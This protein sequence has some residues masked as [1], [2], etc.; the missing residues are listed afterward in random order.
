MT[1]APRFLLGIDYGT[2][3]IGLAWGDRE[4]CLAFALGAHQEGRDGS[5]MDHIAAI[6][7]ERQIQRIVI[8]LPRR[9]DGSEGEIADRARRFAGLLEERLGL[10]CILWDERYSSQEADRWLA[11]RARRGQKGDRDSLAA[12]I[13][14]QSYLD[15]L[16]AGQPEADP[17]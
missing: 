1:D 7:Q 10:T 6:V 8:G 11:G 2:R 4:R 14:L 12:E 16:V 9:A 17:S 3:R 5:V 15:S 13:I